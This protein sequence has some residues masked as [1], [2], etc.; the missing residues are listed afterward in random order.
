MAAGAGYMR[1]RFVSQDPKASVRRQEL[2]IAARRSHSAR[3]VHKRHQA[4]EALLARALK[5]SSEEEH[6]LQPVE[7]R[8]NEQAPN[9]P[10]PTSTIEKGAKDTKVSHAPETT[11]QLGILA[12]RLKGNSDPFAV[13]AIKV[14]PRINQA[15]TFMR[16]TVHPAIYY[17]PIFRRI[18]GHGGTSKQNNWLPAGLAKQ[19]W[20]FASSSL[21][22]EGLAF[23][24]IASYVVNLAE[25]LH[26]STAFNASHLAL[27][28]ITKSSEILRRRL[29]KRKADQPLDKLLISHVYWLLRANVYLTDSVAVESHGAMLSR[30]VIR[31]MADGSVDNLIFIHAATLDSDVSAVHMKRTWFDYSWFAK[32]CAPLWAAVE[33]QLPPVPP[34]I[35]EAVHPNVTNPVIRGVFMQARQQSEY[36]ERPPPDKAWG[37]RTQK[38][39]AYSWFATVSLWGLGSAMKV[40]QDLRDVCGY[41]F[42]SGTLEELTQAA[43]AIGLL[44]YVRAFGH[45]VLVN[46]VNLRDASHVLVPQMK[47]VISQIFE[48]WTVKEMKQFKDAYLWLL[49]LGAFYEQLSLRKPAGVP[50]VWFQHRLVKCALEANK[51]S[52][53]TLSPVLEQFLLV[54]WLEPHGSSWFDTLVD[55]VR[56]LAGLW[57]R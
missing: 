32:I 26:T 22:D 12:R 33:P 15:L 27:A 41:G 51:A 14:S 1:Y 17:Y 2:E 55:D 29:M 21:Q 38:S 7:H 42:A 10:A 24:C 40:Y 44:F 56:P 45:V 43:I 53:E 54:S 34:H 48:R 57:A 16:E 18:Y 50:E 5:P 20:D 6:E 9:V 31:G 11:P 25:F 3:V 35:F 47:M 36:A 52:W 23:A 30:A 37:S 19:G 8:G 13:Y 39:L 4:C 49:Y 46:G 28:M